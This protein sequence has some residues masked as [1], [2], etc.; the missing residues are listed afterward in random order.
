MIAVRLKWGQTCVL[1]PLRARIVS[2]EDHNFG[3]FG[4]GKPP[5]KDDTS[6]VPRDF[7][8]FFPSLFKISARFVYFSNFAVAH[9]GKYSFF[10][11]NLIRLQVP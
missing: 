11:F 3:N 8:S 7:S 10:G 1:S 6:L 4:L 2:D 9:R 5:L